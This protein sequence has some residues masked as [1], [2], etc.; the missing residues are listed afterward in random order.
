MKFLDFLKQAVAK[1]GL[2]SKFAAKELS[3]EE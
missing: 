2:E 1:L 3:P